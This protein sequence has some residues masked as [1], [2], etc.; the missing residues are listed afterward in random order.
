MLNAIGFLVPVLEWQESYDMLEYLVS[1]SV[2]IS[3]GQA[4]N[5]MMIILMMKAIIVIFVVVI[6]SLTV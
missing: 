2:E 1:R 5:S 6:I 4:I 3:Y